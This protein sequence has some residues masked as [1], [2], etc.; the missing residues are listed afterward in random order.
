MMK[1]KQFLATLSLLG[2]FAV[3]SPS[4]MATGDDFDINVA[5][6]H[7]KT[8]SDH[9]AVAKYYEDAAAATQAKMQEQEQ[10]L[11]H[12]QDKS[13]LYGRRA[14]DLQSHTEALLHKYEKEA[15]ASIKQAALHRQ[16]AAKLKENSYSAARLGH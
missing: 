15:D 13:Y 8:P 4:A 9:E 5:T 12:Y 7:A 1:M 6:E 10:L 14:Q 16:M 2:L 3:L 11:E